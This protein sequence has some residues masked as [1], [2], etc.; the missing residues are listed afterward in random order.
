MPSPR[1]VGVATSS[2]AGTPP[3][4]QTCLSC[5]GLEHARQ[6]IDSSGACPHCVAFMAKSL[7]WQ[8]ACQ[9]S[10]SSTDPSLPSALDCEAMKKWGML[11][12]PVMEPLVAGAPVSHRSLTRCSL[13]SQRAA[14]LAA[15]ALN[16]LSL[17]TALVCEDHARTRESVV[18]DEISVIADLC[19]R[20]QRCAVQATGKVIGAFV[21][22]ERAR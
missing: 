10:L 2:R 21:L 9:L 20:V 6:V 12:L 22:Q 16:T 18:L 8:L 19:L 5:L 17:L 1:I 4:H 14:A 15:P 13:H 3:P 7:S 11:H